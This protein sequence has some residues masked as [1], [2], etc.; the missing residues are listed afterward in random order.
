MRQG[1]VRPV[2]VV[3]VD[4]GVDQRLQLGQGGRLNPLGLQ[5]LLQGLLEPLDLPAGGRVVGSGV[6]LEHAQGAELVL[7]AVAAA[8]AAGEPGGK[9]HPVEFLR[10]VKRFRLA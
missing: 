10:D 4:E 7:E 1:P 8:R 2:A 9:H 6:L 3:G 5:P